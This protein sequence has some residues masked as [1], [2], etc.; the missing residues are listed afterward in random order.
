MW[1]YQPTSKDVSYFGVQS[2]PAVADG[3]IHFGS[4]NYVY[5]LDAFMG[6]KVWEYAAN[7][8]IGLNSPAI[9][10][11]ILYITTEGGYVY[12]FGQP[13]ARKVD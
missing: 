9:A 7:G 3:Y 1:S 12:A 10:N 5:C 13:S 8:N 4:S 6:Y 2:S 11:G